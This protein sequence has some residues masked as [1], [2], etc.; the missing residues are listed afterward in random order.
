VSDLHKHL[1]GPQPVNWGGVANA[2]TNS[3]A[4]KRQ[5]RVDEDIPEKAE[6]IIRIQG[7]DFL[8]LGPKDLTVIKDAWREGLID[9]S[10][11]NGVAQFKMTTQQSAVW[12][13]ARSSRG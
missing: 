3:I 5:A 8:G 2:S 9:I 12:K 4:S 10:V 6:A 11:S 7:A 13:K 1:G